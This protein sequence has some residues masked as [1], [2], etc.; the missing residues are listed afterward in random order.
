MRERFGFFY[1][2]VNGTHAI[3]IYEV[4]YI[5]GLTTSLYVISY[6]FTQ[7]ITMISSSRAQMHVTSLNILVSG[8]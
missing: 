1:A 4:R 7:N 2:S 3:G 8:Y 5:W 6:R